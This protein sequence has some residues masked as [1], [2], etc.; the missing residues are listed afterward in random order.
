MKLSLLGVGLLALSSTIGFCQAAPPPAP[1]SGFAP[2]H[3]TINQRRA[4][5]QHRIA[6]G[7]RSGRL[8]ARQANRLERR[9]IRIGRTERHMRA[10]DHG[11]LTR[12]DRIALNHRLNRTSRAIYRNKH[13]AIRQ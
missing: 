3:A 9:E 7:A 12:A 6:Q 5:Q 1:A 11:R 13:R 8:S 10:V 4:M 2:H